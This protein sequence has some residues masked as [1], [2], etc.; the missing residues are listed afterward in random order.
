MTAYRMGRAA[1]HVSVVEPGK[2]TVEGDTLQ[3]VHCGCHF[4]TKP[5]SGKQRGWCMRCNGPHCGRANCWECVPFMKR[6]EQQEARERISR[7][8]DEL[9]RK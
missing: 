1:G 6:I 4:F 9:M 5:G 2:P 3:C 7:H 8:Y